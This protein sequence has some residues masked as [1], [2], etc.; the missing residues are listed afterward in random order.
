METHQRTRFTDRGLAIGPSPRADGAGEATLGGV[1]HGVEHSGEH[2][3][4]IAGELHYWRVDPRDWEPC[5]RTMRACGVAIVSTYVPWGVHEIRPG[6]YDWQGEFDLGQF[7]DRVADAGMRALVRP[8]PHI[9]AELTYFGFPERIL[10]TPELLAITGRDTPAWLPAPTRMFP[11]PSYAARGFQTEVR[12]WFA[13]VGEILAPRLGPDGP[14]AA[15]QVDN[16]TQMFFRMG[17]YDLDYH[18]DAL[19]WWAEFSGER[20]A[21]RTWSESAAGDCVRWVHFKDEYTARSLAWLGRALDDA[22]LK[23]IAR[24]HNAPPCDPSWLDLPRATRAA[25]GPSGLDFYQRSRDYTTTRRRALYL[26]GSGDPLPFAPEVGMGGPPWLPPMSPDDQR[27]TL[28]A[29]L[30]AGVR[31]FNLYMMVERERWYGG[32]ID[33]VGE[34]RPECA[35]LP[36]LIQTLHKVEF[37]ALRRPAPVA[38]IWSRADARFALASS[39]ADPLPPILGEVLGL[40]PAGAAELSTD[41][42]A[43]LH[44]RWLLACERALDFAQIPY[45]ILDEGVEEARL[46]QYRAIIAPTLNRVDRGLWQRLHRAAE[47]GVQIVVGP[48]RPS[49]DEYG[50]DLGSDAE[51]PARAGL[52]R[53]LSLTDTAGFADDLMAVAGDLDDE[54]SAED[55]DIDCALFVDRDR[56]PTVLFVGNRLSSARRAPLLLTARATLADAITGEQFTADSEGALDVP[57]AGYQVRMFVIE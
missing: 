37:C 6:R 53:E 39:V 26:A 50:D 43:T 24:Y 28:L 15:V 41:P 38:L 13:A 49:C 34:L 1:G 33:T 2:M 46:G 16:E 32:V 10:R 3:D 21:P 57:L 8:G 52:I 40:G 12:G 27:D 11:V 22:G 45:D 55:S 4:L 35:W 42:G 36:A 29:L 20:P 44:R 25:A 54:W 56:R 48:H 5:L 31:A 17:A 47:R 9:N 19:A 18:P 30:S 51:L 7:L 23:G 14:V